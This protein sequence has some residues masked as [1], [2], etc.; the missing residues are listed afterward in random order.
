MSAMS[1]D[2][3]DRARVSTISYITR[4]LQ[5]YPS[6]RD[7][8]INQTTTQF[9]IHKKIIQELS[10]RV[11]TFSFTEIRI[12]LSEGC[13]AVYAIQDEALQEMFKL[14][15]ISEEIQ[16]AAARGREAVS[17]AQ[18]RAAREPLEEIPSIMDDEKQPKKAS[19][20]TS[21]VF[22]NDSDAVTCKSCMT[23]APQYVSTSCGHF[24]FC[25]EC[26]TTAPVDTKCPTCRAD[27][28]YLRIYH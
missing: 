4:I 27:I 10:E 12:A 20:I 1:E 23:N 5:S 21:E 18:A 17:A 28:K 11:K 16:T 24:N 26:R 15:K 13:Y 14:V 6:Q 2:K 25:H 22:V 19:V 7:K 9:D 8:M 3:L